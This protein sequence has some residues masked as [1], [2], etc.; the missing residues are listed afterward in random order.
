M[1]KRARRADQ[2]RRRR[3]R[4]RGPRGGGSGVGGGHADVGDGASGFGGA[5]E[6]PAGGVAAG[7]EGELERGGRGADRDSSRGS[8]VNKRSYGADADL[9]CFLRTNENTT[10]QTLAGL[11]GDSH[12]VILNAQS[13]PSFE[14]FHSVQVLVRRGYLGVRR[15]TLLTQS[16]QSNRD[17]RS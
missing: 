9:L 13:S 7:R 5:A 6:S 8:R 16:A 15:P 1:E 2:P 10:W 3:R 17:F 14:S 4:R 11:A 12:L